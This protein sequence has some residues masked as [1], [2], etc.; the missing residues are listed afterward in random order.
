MNKVDKLVEKVA[1]TLR[2]EDN[3][4][5]R[6]CYYKWLAK[7]ILFGNNLAIVHYDEGGF[8]AEI[9]PLE[10]TDAKDKTD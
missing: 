2:K 7:Q 10:E 9:I 1:N 5:Y 6:D 3:P 8:E 4:K